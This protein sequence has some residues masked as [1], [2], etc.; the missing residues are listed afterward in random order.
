MSGTPPVTH[1]MTGSTWGLPTASSKNRPPGRPTRPHPPPA[2][3]RETT[4]PAGVHPVERAGAWVPV[5]ARLTWLPPKPQRQAF[6]QLDRVQRRVW[7]A[8]IAGTNRPKPCHGRLIRRDTWPMRRPGGARLDRREHRAF[9]LWAADCAEHVLQAFERQCPHD[10]RPRRALEVARAWAHGEVALADAREAAFAAHAA[11]RAVDHPAAR[12]AAR[13]AGHA[14]AAAHV[15]DHAGHAA[16][17]A[18][19][20]AGDA[21]DTAGRVIAREREWQSRSRAAHLLP[22]ES[23]A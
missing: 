17:Y 2:R 9:V 11:A 5:C 13:A 21:V 19:T 14:A 23:P 10:A 4:A 20:A 18:L 12:A 15:A 1:T 16:T 3:S 7:I 6:G 8:W 22:V